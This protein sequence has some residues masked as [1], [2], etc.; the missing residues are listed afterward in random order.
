MHLHNINN[1]LNKEYIVSSETIANNSRPLELV[2]VLL[3]AW[4]FRQTV[5]HDWLI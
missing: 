5:F 1:M 3:G 2:S 4:H